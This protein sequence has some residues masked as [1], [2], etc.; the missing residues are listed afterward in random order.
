MISACRN[1]VAAEV[2]ISPPAQNN[3]KCRGKFFADS[4]RPAA[5][6]ISKRYPRHY[7]SFCQYASSLSSGGRSKQEES[8]YRN[9]RTNV[10]PSSSSFA[11]SSPQRV[12]GGKLSAEVCAGME[13][14]SECHCKKR[15]GQGGGKVWEKGEKKGGSR[16]ERER[17][18]HITAR[19]DDELIVLARSVRGKEKQWVCISNGTTA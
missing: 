13:T 2:E 6:H 11:S 15:R 12:S 8:F 19:G 4:C 7:L 18:L 17:E 16:G 1:W 9:I 10:L 3:I 5:G 14:Q